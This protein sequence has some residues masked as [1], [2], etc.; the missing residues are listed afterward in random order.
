ARRGRE[1][2]RFIVV[3][4]CATRRSMNAAGAA[5]R[6]FANSEQVAPRPR[7]GTRERNLRARG[8]RVALGAPVATRIPRTRRRPLFSRPRTMRTA[9]SLSV[10]CAAALSAC[11]SDTSSPTMPTMSA[12]GAANPDRS[13]S[14]QVGQVFTMSNAVAGNAVLVFGRAA[15]GSLHAVGTY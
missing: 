5:A 3:F 12:A 8:V 13:S 1:E 10:L 15:D 9:A 11:S 14:Q 6:L 2:A 4:H 7:L